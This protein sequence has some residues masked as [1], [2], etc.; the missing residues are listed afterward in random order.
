MRMVKNN[1]TIHSKATI[2][3]GRDPFNVAFSHFLG[4]RSVHNQRLGH[5]NRTF[6]GEIL[7]FQTLERG[8]GPQP[9]CIQ[10]RFGLFLSANLCGLSG[11]GAKS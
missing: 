8:I 10:D 1:M 3:P 7:F 5:S 11:I 9:F 2:N 6:Y 4:Y